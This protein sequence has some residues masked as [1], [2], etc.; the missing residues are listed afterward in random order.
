MG[1]GQWGTREQESAERPIADCPLPIAGSRVLVI[2]LGIEGVALTRFLAGQGARVTVNDAR[3]SDQ[4][5]AR[6]A[7]LDGV[8]FTPAFGHHNPALVKD[9]DAVYVSQGV[10]LSLP[11]I[12]EARRRG[13]PVGSIATLLFEICPGSITGITGSAGKTT[14]TSLVNAIL[15][16]SG[17]PHILAG[18]I[19][20]WPLDALAAATPDTFVVAEI[21]HTQLQLTKRSPHVACITNV[22]PNHLDQFSWSEYVDLKRNLIRYQT[23][24]DVAV[25]NL[26][27]PETRGF[28]RDTSAELLWFSL[29]SDLPGDGAYVRDGMIV[30]RHNGEEVQVIRS[31]ESRLRG[32]HNVENVL[33][34][35]AVAGACGIPMTIAG[36]AVRAFRGVPHRLEPVATLHGITF[37][38]DS[39]ATAPERTLAGMRSFDEP[40][41]LLLGGRDK[42][43]PLDELAAEC[44]RRC[45]AVLCFGEAGDLFAGAIRAAAGRGPMTVRRTDTVDDALAQAAR[46]AR[47]GDVVLFA[48]AGTSFD[49]YPNFERRGDHFRRLVAAL[50]GE[51]RTEH[52]TAAPPPPART[53]PPPLPER[54]EQH[55]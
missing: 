8:R 16:R 23:P 46:L 49:A 9:I 19:G 39:I 3:S 12:G 6:L 44:G 29:G 36:E 1:N 38:N 34:A 37:V 55:R 31:D 47:A 28:L 50:A 18:N 17:R 54:Q 4:L 10:P 7:E 41:V 45:R 30:W 24:R 14:T 53:T 21:S 25:L 11:L 15:E 20:A 42:N 43:L 13:V 40:I 26:D 33:A 22:T 32:R 48:P 51:S 52:G 27:N 35:I 5:T 2:G